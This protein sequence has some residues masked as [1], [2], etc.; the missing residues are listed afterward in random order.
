MVGRHCCAAGLADR[1]VSPT[2]LV[3]VPMLIE[4]AIGL[5]CGINIYFKNTLA[6]PLFCRA[7]NF[8]PVVWNRN[9]RR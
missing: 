2:G 5:F 8:E 7:N 3:Y 4:T 6:S 1:Q 9:L